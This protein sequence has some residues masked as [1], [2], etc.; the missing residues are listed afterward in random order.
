MNDC[1]LDSLT[2][3]AYKASSLMR[4]LKL[5]PRVTE[6]YHFISAW[7]PP[8][9]QQRSPLGQ[10]AALDALELSGPHRAP[11]APYSEALWELVYSKRA[12]GL[13]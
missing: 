8:K 3:T 10:Y 4:L 6:A 12:R 11:G 5:L 1:R 2:N 13:D 7:Q 9:Y